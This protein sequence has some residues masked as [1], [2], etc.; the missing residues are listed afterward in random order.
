LLLVEFSV[1]RPP[2][3]RSVVVQ[4]ASPPEHDG[5]AWV[6]RG[7]EVEKPHR[8]RL[9]LA[10]FRGSTGIRVAGERSE[11]EAVVLRDDNLAVSSAGR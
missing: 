2:H 8:F 11:V 3:D 7:L 9:D 6:R 5:S 10:A 4:L 1:G